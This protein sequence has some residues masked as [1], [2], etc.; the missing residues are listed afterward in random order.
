MQMNKE[1]IASEDE[2]NDLYEGHRDF[3]LFYYAPGKQNDLINTHKS[4]LAG[5]FTDF[6]QDYFTGTIEDNKVHYLLYKS[7]IDVIDS[8]Q[9]M[10]NDK[11]YDPTQGH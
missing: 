7:Q 10:L 5:V 11:A 1:F 6:N 9:D 3:Q 4:V 2:N 8:F